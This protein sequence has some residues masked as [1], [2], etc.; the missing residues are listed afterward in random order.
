M[1]KKLLYGKIH[2]QASQAANANQLAGQSLLQA[3][4]YINQPQDYQ[5]VNNFYATTDN[6][7]QANS[8]LSMSSNQPNNFFYYTYKSN[9]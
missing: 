8:Y 5:Y 1:A 4:Y 7:A 9:L 6:L 3:S 2:S